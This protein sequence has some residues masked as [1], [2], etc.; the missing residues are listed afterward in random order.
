MIRY[1]GGRLVQSAIVVVG[2]SVIVFAA[3]H[4]AGDPVALMLPPDASYQDMQRYRRLLGFDEPIPE[5]YLHYVT[6][7]LRGNFGTSIRYNLPAVPLMLEHLPATVS[8]A[9]A[10]LTWSTVLGVVIGTS[11]AL[12]RG[13]AVD[14]AARILALAGQAIPVF[15][16]GPMLI[17]YFSVQLGWFP[18][19]GFGLGSHLVLPAVTL[20]AYYLAIVIRLMRTSV[21]ASLQQDHVRSARAK[22][23]ASRRIIVRHVLRNSWLPAISM[24]GLQAGS[25]MG[26]AVVTEVVF[27]WPGLGRLAAQAI[28]G[29]D[30]PLV[31]AIVLLSAIVFVLVNLTADVLYMI[32]DPRIRYS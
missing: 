4:L 9:V 22:G 12:H 14:Y 11:A 21:L 29:R 32:A 30:F 15:W 23:L 5:Q 3:L 2:V 24:L 19:G 31:Q 13:G 8:L 26:G 6:K 18:T 10:A 27:A 28:S 16:L 17:L 20:G 7:A 1:L 25:V